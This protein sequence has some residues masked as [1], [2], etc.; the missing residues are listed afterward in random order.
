MTDLSYYIRRLTEYA[1]A[2]GII[3]AII[4]EDHDADTMRRKVQRA[5]DDLERKLE[6]HHETSFTKTD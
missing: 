6:E 4:H 3:R 1:Y 2:I 5:I